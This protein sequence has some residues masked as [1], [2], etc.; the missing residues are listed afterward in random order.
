MSAWW[1]EDPLASAAR[2]RARGRY[3]AIA[4]TATKLRVASFTIDGQAVVAVRTA[5]RSST[6]CAGA[7]ASARPCCMPFDLV[8][9]GVD[10]LRPLTLVDRKKRLAKLVGRRML[11][12]VI[13]RSDSPLRT[14]VQTVYPTVP[15]II[16]QQNQFNEQER[17]SCHRRHGRLRRWRWWHRRRRAFPAGPRADQPKKASRSRAPRI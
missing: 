13:A 9:L 11:P 5:S 1:P 6:H 15:L 10:D 7:A 17:R 12:S 4:S 16:V 8:E 3:P 2:R 14:W